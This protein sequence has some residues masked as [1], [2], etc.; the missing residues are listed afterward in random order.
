[1]II[2]RLESEYIMMLAKLCHHGAEFASHEE[3]RE[4]LNYLAEYFDRSWYAYDEDKKE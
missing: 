4:K 1:M 2:V 3:E